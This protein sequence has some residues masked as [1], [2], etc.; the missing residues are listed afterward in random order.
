MQK[1]HFLIGEWVPTGED[2]ARWEVSGTA[3]GIA[4]REFLYASYDWMAVDCEACLAMR[5]PN[6]PMYTTGPKTSIMR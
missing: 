2:M 1:V 5:N 6:T 3:C 4:V